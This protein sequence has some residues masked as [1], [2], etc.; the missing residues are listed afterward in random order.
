MSTRLRKVEKFN[1][2]AVDHRELLNVLHTFRNGDFSVRLPAERTGVAGKI[3]D[4]LN[5]IIDNNDRL[6]KELGR[7]N[8][9][10]GKEGKLTHRATLPRVIGGWAGCIESVNSL[11]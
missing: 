10:V 9:I 2:D 11:V 4:A 3:Y 1:P 5:E 6:N 8:R 7:L